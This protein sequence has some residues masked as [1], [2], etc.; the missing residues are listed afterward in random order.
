MLGRK[1]A[2][3]CQY[4]CCSDDELDGR[5]QIVRRNKRRENRAWKKEWAS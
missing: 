4:G 3:S 5:K 2:Q 1:K